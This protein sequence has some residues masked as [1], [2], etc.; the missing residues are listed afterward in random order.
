LIIILPG[1]GDLMSSDF[2]KPKVHR[3]L[4]PKAI[5][6]SAWCRQGFNKS[7]PGLGQNLLEM[8]GLQSG[9]P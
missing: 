6:K 2:P 7:F 8:P 5:S 1:F 3:E 4:E 9:S